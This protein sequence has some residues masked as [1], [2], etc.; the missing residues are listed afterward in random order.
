MGHREE[1]PEKG[2]QGRV[3]EAERRPA[4]GEDRRNECRSPEHSGEREVTAEIRTG[5]RGAG[6]GAGRNGDIE[7]GKGDGEEGTGN[8]APCFAERARD[9]WASPRR[10]LGGS[11]QTGFSL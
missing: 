3:R 1:E 8:R 5:A 6:R 4:L 10:A 7:G 11:E 2:E 9:A